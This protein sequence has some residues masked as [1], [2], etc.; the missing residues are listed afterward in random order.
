M[1]PAKG[2]ARSESGAWRSVRESASATFTVASSCGHWP[3]AAPAR[4]PG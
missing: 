4:A 1:D 2:L 3:E